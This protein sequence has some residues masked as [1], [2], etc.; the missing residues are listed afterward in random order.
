MSCRCRRAPCTTASGRTGGSFC[1][2]RGTVSF[3]I[4]TSTFKGESRVGNQFPDLPATFRAFLCRFI[5]K[6]L[7][8]FELIAAGLALVFVNGHCGKSSCW[9]VHNLSNIMIRPAFCQG[10]RAEICGNGSGRYSSARSERTACCVIP[11]TCTVLCRDFKPVAMETRDLATWSRR[12]RNSM[13]SLLAASSTGGAVSLIFISP[14]WRPQSSFR[15]ARG[16][17]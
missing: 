12:A 6:L 3:C 5:G 4:P 17:T 13:H 10:P 14:S 9:C 8:Q 1:R 11:S 2:F 15:E 16:W 7:A